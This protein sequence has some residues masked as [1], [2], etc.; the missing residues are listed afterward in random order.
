[1]NEDNEL[2]LFGKYHCNYYSGYELNPEL[3]VMH[4]EDDKL[5]QKKLKKIEKN[6]KIILDN[7]KNNC[8]NKCL[9]FLDM[10]NDLYSHSD[11]E[12]EK[13]W[14]E[15]IWP[16]I[17][18]NEKYNKCKNYFDLKFTIYKLNK[19]QLDDYCDEWQEY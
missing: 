1:K 13:W 3:R 17:K 19:L 18:D 6:N 15:H 12:H 14:Q 10:I 5:R 16:K 7:L 8:E 2:N 11:D 4:I 9:E